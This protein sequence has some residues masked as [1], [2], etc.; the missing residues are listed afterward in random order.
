MARR[1]L[2]GWLRP[3][4]REK[5]HGAC[6]SIE[7][8]HRDRRPGGERKLD[9]PAVSAL[10]RRD[11]RLGA[12]QDILL[13]LARCGLGERVNKGHGAR[14]FEVGHVLAGELS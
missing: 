9:R 3:A 11:G 8:E 13:N 10:L 4:I 14:A 12:S 2:T 7:P 1:S 6:L 5:G